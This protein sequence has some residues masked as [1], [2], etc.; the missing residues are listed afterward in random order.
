MLLAGDTDRDSYAT[1]TKT[2]FTPKTGAVPA[3]IRYIPIQIRL[4]YTLEFVHLSSIIQSPK[5][6]ESNQ[7]RLIENELR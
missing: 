1:T 5:P 6:T 3:L 4:I 2:A 7:T